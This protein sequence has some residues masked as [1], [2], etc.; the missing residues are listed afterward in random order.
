MKKTVQ[1]NLSGQIFTLDEDA[2]DLLSSYLNQIGKL[3]DRSPGKDEI[4]T[5]IEMRIAEL[6]LEKLAN[7]KQV[8]MIQDVEAVITIMGKP[9]QFEA[10]EDYQDTSSNYAESNHKSKRL[11][12]D[13]DNAVVG[14]VCAGVGQYFGI[15]PIWLR[16]FMAI[17]IIVFGSGA[18][19]YIILWVIVPA[20]RTTAEKL[21]MKGEPVN[22]NNIGK[23][24]ED[25]INNLGAKLGS[26]GAKNTTR[27]MASGLDRFFSFLAELIRGFL[28]VF[29]KILGAVLFL[30]GLFSIIGILGAVFGIADFFHWGNDHWG[31][32][33]TIYE[34]GDVV[35]SSSEWFAAAVV[36][37]VI[38][39]AIPFIGM[40]YGGIGLLFPKV[41]IPYLGVS[42]VGLWFIGVSIVVFTAF[43]VG[44]EFSKE[45]TSKTEF[46]LSNLNQL[47]DTIIVDLG[48]DPFH[49]STSKSYRIN[50]NDFVFKT[51]E[52][53]IL[54]GNV[55]F[56]VEESRTDA[57]SLEIL[58]SSQ[59]ASFDEARNRAEAIKYETKI[60]SNKIT[61]D[62]Y[63]RFPLNQMLRDQ[64]VNVTLKL[65][66][67][68]VVYL[69]EG[70]QRVIDDID[71]IDDIYD[72]HMVN[73]YWK[74]TSRGLLCLDCDRSTQKVDGE[75]YEPQSSTTI[76]I[77]NH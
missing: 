51:E 19:L 29:G 36:G 5:D 27:K 74:M 30:V 13:Q 34:F 72:P 63:F 1:V 32:S 28:K 38:T 20:A 56:N 57:I 15:E 3:Y 59:G 58:K 2:F 48:A 45:D 43:G 10:E 66:T 39:F 17:S 33:M 73:H 76:V 25:E 21:S 9:E 31:N 8:V 46:V 75:Y 11:F 47:Q 64:D 68:S 7:N 77:E 54:F 24:I 49:L 67:G 61:V 40:I 35:F 4:I 71:N 44:R 70:L 41:R 55:S 22:I 50:R 18:L 53:E 23:T 69:T 52:N 6:L 37:L 62:A 12:R 60:D 16:L 14:G 26:N 65:P 42:L